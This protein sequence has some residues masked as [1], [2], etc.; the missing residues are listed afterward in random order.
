MDKR[1]ISILVKTL[2]KIDFFSSLTA[3]EI[4]KILSKFEEKIFPK[5]KI[6]VSAGK[7]GKFFA[8]ISKG[9]ANVLKKKRLAGLKKIAS[10]R[11]GDYFGE[12][13]LISN[14]PASATVKTVS[15]TE[16]LLLMK[17]DFKNIL[18][19]NPALAEKIKYSAEKRKLDS[20]FR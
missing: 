8:V 5:N 13:S 17:T 6:I 14:M 1:N 16:I 12:I 10:L 19:Q 20:S 18:N 15:E 4:D 2:Y 11:P 3:A 7:E 9:K